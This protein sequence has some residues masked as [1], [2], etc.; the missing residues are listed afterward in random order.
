MWGRFPS[1]G[2]M[3]QNFMM[4]PNQMGPNP[5]MGPY[6]MM[7][8][9]PMGPNQAR[10]MGPG[11]CGGWERFPSPS[12]TYPGSMMDPSSQ[13][14]QNPFPN[15]GQLMPEGVNNPRMNTQSEDRNP[16]RGSLSPF[17]KETSRRYE[18]PDSSTSFE[19]KRHRVKKAEES[20]E[21][22]EADYNVG[23]YCD[24]CELHLPSAHMLWRHMS[25]KKHMKALKAMDAGRPL[26]KKIQE[27]KAENPSSSSVGEEVSSIEKSFASLTA[28]EP[29]VGL[30]F[31]VET[32]DQSEDLFICELCGSKCNQNNMVLHVIGLKHRMAYLKR[33]DPERYARLKKTQKRSKLT[34]DTRQLC[35]EVESTIGRGRPRYKG[36]KQRDTDRN[37]NQYER[38]ELST[39]ERRMAMEDL[40]RILLQDFTSR[41]LDPGTVQEMLEERM[42][43]MKEYEKRGVSFDLAKER[44]VEDEDR[45]NLLLEFERQTLSFDE[46][47][48][49]IS[50]RMDLLKAYIVNDCPKEEARKRVLDDEVIRDFRKEFQRLGMERHQAQKH[51]EKR[52]WMLERL[53]YKGFSQ[54][55]A[56]RKVMKIER[57]LSRILQTAKEESKKHIG[58]SELFSWMKAAED[59]EAFIEMTFHELGLSSSQREKHIEL[60]LDYLDKY[61]KENVPVDM[62]KKRVLV[63]DLP[64]L[65][66]DVEESKAEASAS[67][68]PEEPATSASTSSVGA[69]EDVMQRIKVFMTK[70]HALLEIDQQGPS[71]VDR[72]KQ[73]A[74]FDQLNQ[75]EM[76]SLLSDMIKSNLNAIEA[77]KSPLRTS[78][79]EHELAVLQ[80]T[81]FVQQCSSV[82]MSGALSVQ[83]INIPLLV[84]P[85]V[86]VFLR[87]LTEITENC[88]PCT[89]LGILTVL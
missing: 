24:L 7:G 20:E 37:I 57:E 51:V 83:K 46:A 26:P 39:E 4:G 84:F 82:G 74:M 32:F 23:P 58:V 78:S 1:A 42:Q 48:E 76:Q 15:S 68:P 13:G 29:V 87:K 56:S 3:G 70:L 22:E 49:R 73:L 59:L 9:N 18:E 63:D 47:E 38:R 80:C 17:E 66:D 8:P 54:G 45:W 86:Q 61:K 67:T 12:F 72:E 33:C 52:F 41:N 19:G 62:A 40:K 14:L 44:V 28:D 81:S 25:G 36:P 53:H 11:P 77:K 16:E 89:V 75:L 65:E 5:M 60:S 6:P 10:M 27:R 43:L 34:E 55:T 71:P 35:K 88:F 31:V 79:A 21:E 30:G 85:K 2:Q 64:V 69:K 50:Y